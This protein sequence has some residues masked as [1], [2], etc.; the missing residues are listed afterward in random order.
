MSEIAKVDIK[1]KRGDTKDF[2][3]NLTQKKVIYPL[4]GCTSRLSVSD[5]KAP[6]TN[7]YVFQ[8]V[9]TIN[10]VEGSITFPF[11]A[12]NVDHLGTFYY[13]VEIIDGDGKIATVLEGKWSFSQDITKD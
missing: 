8:S 10:D 12:Q 11:T 5:K 7:N 9:G 13:D 1:R 2:K 3:I 4:A 6:T